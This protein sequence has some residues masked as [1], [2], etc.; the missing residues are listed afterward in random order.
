[1]DISTDILR[2]SGTV[3]LVPALG[4]AFKL[5]MLI[6]QTVQVCSLEV[7]ISST[8]FICA[9]QI[10]KRNTARL[11]YLAHLVA[12]YLVSIAEHMHGKWDIAPSALKTKLD[13]FQV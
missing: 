3:S 6:I 1:M 7:F 5:A 10:S 12:D 8:D 2:L 9:S 11:Q 13:E 4:V